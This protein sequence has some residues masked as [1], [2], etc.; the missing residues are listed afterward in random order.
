[1]DKIKE[2]TCVD[3]GTQNCKIKT[4]TYPEFCLTTHLDESDRQWALERY[5]QGRNREIM[6]VSAEVEYEGYGH[7]TPAYR[8]SWSLPAGSGPERSASP[9]ASV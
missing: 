8:R 6:R 7:W 1:M 4:A 5:D 3:C 9:T 2:P